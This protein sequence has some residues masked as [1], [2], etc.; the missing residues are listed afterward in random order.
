LIQSNETSPTSTYV[1][2]ILNLQ[3]DQPTQFEKKRKRKKKRK[4]RRKKKKRK[5]KKKMMKRK[6]K[7]KRKNKMKRK[8][9]TKREVAP[10]FQS[11]KFC[12]EPTITYPVGRSTG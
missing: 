6:K 2:R 12:Y 5:R 9:K 10:S 1:N 4:R 3:T 7:R 8:K 11:C